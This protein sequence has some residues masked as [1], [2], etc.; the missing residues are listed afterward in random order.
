MLRGQHRFQHFLPARQAGEQ[1]RS[2]AS[3]RV[4][5][6]LPF[7]PKALPE[8]WSVLLYSRWLR[9]TSSRWAAVRPS[10][11]PSKATGFRAKSSQSYKRTSYGLIRAE[12][13]LFARRVDSAGGIYRW[14]AAKNT[15][16]AGLYRHHCAENPLAVRLRRGLKRRSHNRRKMDQWIGAFPGALNDTGDLP[17]YSRGNGHFG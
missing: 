6:A 14:D 7:F 13:D 16:D 15:G 2:G 4:A 5:A 12:C 11:F 17:V 1:H 8:P 9:I 3:L 10:S